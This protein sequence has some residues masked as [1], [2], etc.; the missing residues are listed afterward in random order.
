MYI[1]AD[2]M[3]FIVTRAWVRLSR[4]YLNPMP[5]VIL[6]ELWAVITPKSPAPNTPR[7]IY[8]VAE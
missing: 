1:S 5:L 3:Y 2:H 8:I 7:L 6:T 4:T